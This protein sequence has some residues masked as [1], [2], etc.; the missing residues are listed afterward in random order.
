MV[1]ISKNENKRKHETVNFVNIMR[2]S[3]IYSFTAQ[4]LLNDTNG[5]TALSSKQL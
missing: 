3:Y 4:P 2:L 1:P 5:N